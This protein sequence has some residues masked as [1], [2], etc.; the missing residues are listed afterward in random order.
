MKKIFQVQY[1]ITLY[2]NHEPYTG[3]DG[4]LTV[5]ANNQKEAKEKV[6]LYF[7]KKYK[8]YKITNHYKKYK[9]TLEL[10]I[11][12]IKLFKIDIL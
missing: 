7:T 4:Y 5:Y 12:N 3:G 2:E 10:V 6:K 9:N 8:K 1:G 11:H